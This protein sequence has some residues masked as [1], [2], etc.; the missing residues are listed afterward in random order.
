MHPPRGEILVRRGRA[1]IRTQS[2]VE[3]CKPARNPLLWGLF[4]AIGSLLPP[5]HFRGLFDLLLPASALVFLLLYF[6]R[7]RFAWH[8]LATYILLAAPLYILLSPSW[9]LQTILHPSF[10]WFPVIG[11][12]V[13]AIL[14]FWSRKRYFSYLETARIES[15]TGKWG[16]VGGSE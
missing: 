9:R 2:L 7:S 1:M 4:A 6:L 12:C 10:I 3:K 11:T 14:V 5:Y 15:K 8:V 16:S 13:C